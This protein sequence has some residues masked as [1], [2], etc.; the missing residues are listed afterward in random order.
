MAFRLSAL[1][2]LAVVLTAVPAAA[3]TSGFGIGP[4]LTFVR[5]GDPDADSQRFT[6]AA[7]R[8]GG[9]KTALELAMDFRSSVGDDLTERIKDYPIQASLL[10]FPIR[11]RLAPYLVGGLGWYSQRVETL[12]PVQTEAQTT[13]KVGYHAGVGGELGL[14][15]RFGI[16]GDYR[17]TFIRFGGEDSSSLINL[18]LV[19]RLKMAHEGSMFTWGANFY[20]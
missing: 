6:G 13:R 18:P 1:A 20:F 16:Y 5:G 8:L 7:I 10:V 11:T 19:N 12:G 2:L 17:Y 14:H 4:R 15:R 9:G 3:Q